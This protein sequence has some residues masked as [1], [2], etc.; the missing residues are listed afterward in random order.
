MYS[1]E[2]PA[3]ARQEIKFVSYEHQ[4]HYLLSWIRLH[5]VGFY[6]PFPD[7]WI[8]NVYFDTHSYHAYSQ[9]LSGASQRVKLRYR[10]YGE[11]SLPDVG[12]LELKCR[13][14][15]FGWKRRYPVGLMPAHKGDSWKGIRTQIHEQISLEG[16]KVLEVNP[17]P[18]IINR[19]YR[20]YFVS[21]NGKVRITVD[22]HQAVWDQRYRAHPYF[23]KKTNIPHTL[24]V[25]VKF[26]RKDREF[27]SRILQGIPVRV[28]RHS[29][30]ING[31]RAISR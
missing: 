18:V 17:V 6:Q 22:L 30:Y 26:S 19:Y 25:E 21:K 31:V 28:S 20:K 2:I 5:P 4:L 23:G 13:R 7:R 9:N 29:K 8:N 11:T 24:V 16:Q 12:V 1:N 27:A 3:D 14:N 10:W 15:Y